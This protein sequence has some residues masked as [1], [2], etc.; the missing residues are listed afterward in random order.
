[1]PDSLSQ[2]T[3]D[4]RV[5]IA[6][7]PSASYPSGPESENEVSRALSRLADNLGWSDEG[8]PFGKVVPKG[9][10]VLIKPN[11][12]LHKNEG[13]SGLDCLVTHTSVIRATVEA[14]LRTDAE[15]VLVGDAPIQG[16]DFDAMV[17]SMGLRAWARE[18]SA[19]DSRFKGPQ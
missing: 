11:L 16:C 7:L 13:A 3:F 1:M 18:Q 8:G 9:A 2:H 17:E 6:R 4:P 19:R 5:G 14:V 10:R 12:V 15:E